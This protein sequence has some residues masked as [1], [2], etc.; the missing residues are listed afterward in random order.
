M[1][2]WGPVKKELEQTKFYKFICCIKI[3]DAWTAEVPLSND[4]V[5]PLS[6]VGAT[7]NSYKGTTGNNQ[8]A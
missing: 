7:T 8:Y 2:L 5:D 6:K 4:E 1:I 3:G